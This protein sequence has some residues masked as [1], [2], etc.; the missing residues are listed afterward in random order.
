VILLC[1]L[2]NQPPCP[3]I[4]EPIEKMQ[5][6]YVVYYSSTKKNEITLFAEKYMEPEIIL[7]SKI[8][9]SQTNSPCFIS[10]A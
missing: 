10:F 9:Q 8:S 7:L 6:T 3:T 4:N 5:Y 2:L 1:N